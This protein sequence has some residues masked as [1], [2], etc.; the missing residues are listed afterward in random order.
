MDRVRVSLAS[1][2]RSLGTGPGAAKHAIKRCW[3]FIA[4]DRVEP[5]VAMAG[6]VGK[7]LH[8]RR[9]PLLVALDWTDIRDHAHG[10][11]GRQ[12]TL[13]PLGLGELPQDRLAG[14]QEPQQL[15]GGP[16]GTEGVELVGSLIRFP[17]N[18]RAPF[19][20]CL[21]AR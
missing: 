14:A 8:K 20:A 2:G 11:R 6:V 4:N 3:R 7:L 13:G 1:L 16:V 12:G 9:K 17:L 10:Q 19:G 15:R 18:S 21:V 5:S